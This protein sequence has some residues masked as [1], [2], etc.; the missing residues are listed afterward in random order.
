MKYI[1]NLHVINLNR[2]WLLVAAL[3]AGSFAKIAHRAISLRLARL[4]VVIENMINIQLATSI[5]QQ[6]TFKKSLLIN[7]NH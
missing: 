1:L 4:L 6:A 7:F 2:C 5:Q 3:Q